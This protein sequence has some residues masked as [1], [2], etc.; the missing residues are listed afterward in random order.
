MFEDEFL[1][2]GLEALNLPISGE[3]P[4]LLK[5]YLSVIELWNPSY[6]LVASN[7][8]LITRHVLD[9][10]AGLAAIRKIAAS[11]VADLGSGAGFPGIPL[12]VFLKDSQFH[13]IERSGRRAGFLRNAVATLNLKNVEVWEK[14]F[15]EINQDLRFELITFRAL[16]VINDSLLDRLGRLLTVSGHIVAYK[17]RHSQTW[18]EIKSI[19]KS[20]ES[21]E[22]I[23]LDVPGLDEERCLVLLKP[24]RH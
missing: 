2:E 19:A 5:T 21:Y 6:K 18:R 24:L 13:L 8:N 1:L 11:T 14:Q 9:S 10:L 7:E 4:A 3:S 16:S 20:L 12:A 17:G 22:L 15:E 23:P